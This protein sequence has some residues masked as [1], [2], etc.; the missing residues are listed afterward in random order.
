MDYDKP[1]APSAD[2]AIERLKVLSQINHTQRELDRLEMSLSVL[3][4][5]IGDVATTDVVA[6]QYGAE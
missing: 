6:D 2:F 3:E 1:E 4:S 5:R